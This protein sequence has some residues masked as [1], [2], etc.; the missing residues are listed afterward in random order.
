MGFS[1]IDESIAVNVIV[2]VLPA[3]LEEIVPGIAAAAL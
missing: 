2:Q 3:T 1:C